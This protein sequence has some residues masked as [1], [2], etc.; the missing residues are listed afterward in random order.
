MCGM[1]HGANRI[2]MKGPLFEAV[3]LARVF[4]D[5][6]TFV[7]C[8][9][10][11]DPTTIMEDYTNQKER[12]DFD[13][14]AFVEQNFSLPETPKVDDHALKGLPMDEYISRLWPLLSR[15]PDPEAKWSTLIPL[16]YPYIVP[17]GRFREIYYWDTFFTSVGL[18]ACG[19]NEMVRN[20]AR[21]FAHLIDLFG[22]I[23]NG[24]RYYYTERSQ[25]PFFCSLVKLLEDDNRVSSIAEFLPQLQK[26]YG[27]WTR[28]KSTLSES[29][30]ASFK[31]VML[32]D[33]S[34]L[35]RYYAQGDTPRP[36]SYWEDHQLCKK[37]GPVS[38]AAFYR[39][40]RSAAESGW[41]F[42]SRWF[43]NNKTIET[44]HTTDVIP[45]DLNCILY[46]ME[47]NLARWYDALDKQQQAETMRDAAARRKKAIQAN[48]WSE[49]AGYYFDLSRTTGQPTETWSLAGV[50][51]LYFGL[52]TPEQASK[53]ADVLRSRFLQAGGLL[54]TLTEKT[55][56]QWDMP[57]GWA[58]LHWLAVQG[59]LRY[60]HVELASEIATRFIHSAQVQYGYID[61]ILEKYNM[62]DPSEKAGGGEYGVQVGFGWSNGIII[63]LMK[64]PKLK[65][66]PSA[67][68]SKQRDQLTE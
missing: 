20:M 51:P 58:P 42:S 59:L 13:L 41:D 44:I 14:A 56:Q 61:K 57:N 40:I 50:Y 19:N 55:G 2:Q 48:C 1:V 65:L 46:D 62:L 3:Q 21:N 35:N 12:P 6:K 60:G 9:P 52:A 11:R 18:N 63:A 43:A 31:S 22:F 67:I 54:T 25:P 68:S 4:P 7:D 49:I 30:R 33:G 28:G 47:V 29:V 36:E 27:Y 32:P 10:R 26:E 38:P 39:N 45:V 8:L 17:G 53:V 66:K 64:E 34:V 16:P 5:Q 23:P 15:Q 24:N 37:V